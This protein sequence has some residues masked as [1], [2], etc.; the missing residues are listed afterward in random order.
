MKTLLSQLEITQEEF[1]G[2]YTKAYKN[3][4]SLEVLEKGNPWLQDFIKK[5]QLSAVRAFAEEI[6]MKGKHNCC[7]DNSCLGC[8]EL[9][10][11]S[12]FNE[13]IDKKIEDLTK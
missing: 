10:M 2:E 6:K 7:G 1:I 9:I 11:E 4:L 8:S 12:I 5:H 3:V 13:H